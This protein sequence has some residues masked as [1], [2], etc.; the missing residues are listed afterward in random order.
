MVRT[1]PVDSLRAVTGTAP[2]SFSTSVS[3]GNS[4]SS[5]SP[6]VMS[7]TVRIAGGMVKCMLSTL[8]LRS[9][10]TSSTMSRDLKLL[11]LDAMMQSAGAWRSTS[12]NVL[13]LSGSFSGTASTTSHASVTAG[14]I[15]VKVL[16]E[17][18]VEGCEGVQAEKSDRCASMYSAASE[19]ACEEGS[20]MCTV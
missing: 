11:L 19:R 3:M 18:R 14:G 1:Y 7:S 2:H 15:S 5:V 13:T 4:S 9:A 17:P 12:A 6:S 8:L 16:A 10:D 20:R